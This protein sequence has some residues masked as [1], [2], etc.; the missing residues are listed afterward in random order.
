MGF[1]RHGVVAV[2]AAMMIATPVY[3]ES[4]SDVVDTPPPPATAPI[5]PTS[6]LT[7][8]A[9]CS[10]RAS[11]RRPTS[12]PSSPHASRR[13][14]SGVSSGPSGDRCQCP[15]PGRDHLGREQLRRLLPGADAAQPVQLRGNGPGGWTAYASSEESIRVSADYIGKDYARPGAA[16]TGRQHRGGRQRLCVGWRLGRQGGH[17][18]QSIG[19]SRAAPYAAAIALPGSLPRA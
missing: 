5:P 8:A 7:P 16:T 10:S 15:L 13:D 6:L 18:R 2:A 12:T 9:T 4:P 3:A 17:C 14:G 11:R 1:F 19:P